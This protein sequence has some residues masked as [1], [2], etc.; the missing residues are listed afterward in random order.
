MNQI[1]SKSDFENATERNCLYVFIDSH[2]Q[3]ISLNQIIAQKLKATSSMLRSIKIERIINEVIAELPN[4]PIISGIDVLFN[5]CYKV[6]VLD[7]LVQA[8]KQ[9]NFTLIWPGIL[10][11]NKLIYSEEGFADYKEFDIS[12]Y[13]IICVTE[14]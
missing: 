1:I 11:G 3:S 8:D 12:K 4:N 9:K 10:V 14:E 13:N 7:I 2:E 6:D 5:P